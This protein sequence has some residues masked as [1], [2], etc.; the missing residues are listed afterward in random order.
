MPKKCLYNF[1]KQPWEVFRISHDF[2][3]EMETGEALVLGSCT[4]TAVLDSDGTT[5]ATATV[6]ETSTVAVLDSTKLTVVVK[7]GTDGV[8]YILTFRG[9]ISATKKFEADIGMW[10]FD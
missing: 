4:V 2:S 5:S 6:I 9:Y 1:K 10:V 7:A 8:K 3:T